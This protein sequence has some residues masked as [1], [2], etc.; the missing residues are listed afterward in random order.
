MTDTPQPA[1]APAPAPTPPAPPAPAGGEKPWF[2]GITGDHLGYIQNR[3]LDKKPLNEAILAT[4]DAHRN[5]E[6]K[7]GVPADQLVR[8]PKDINDKATADALWNK[9]GRPEKPEGYNFK[10]VQGVDD[11]FRTWAAPVAHKL[12]LTGDQAVGFTKELAARVAA[13]NAEEA[14]RVKA[15]NTV[16]EAD[17]KR[18]WGSAYEGNLFVAQKAFEKLGF[19]PEMV[20]AMQTQV[21]F[22]QVMETFLNIGQKIGEDKYVQAPA[23]G[24]PGRY[25]QE[26]AKAWLV[27]KKGDTEWGKRLIAGD[28]EVVREW[29]DMSR[30]AVGA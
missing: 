4:I 25:T 10:D 18:N 9:L 14:A 22:K 23:G 12:G 3:G 8:L 7:L 11:D 28:S 21:G 16:Q 13:V 29:N 2:D 1:P 15:E 17:L 6:Q 30:I 5:A 20:V 26:Q 27:E 24:A 19:T